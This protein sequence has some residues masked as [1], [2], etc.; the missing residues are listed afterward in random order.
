MEKV[1]IIGGG[2]AGIYALK[3]LVKNKNNTHWQTHLS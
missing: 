1:V 3:E 2:Y